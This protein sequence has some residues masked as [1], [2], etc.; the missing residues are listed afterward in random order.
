MCAFLIVDTAVLRAE[1]Q[2]QGVSA[3][4]STPLGDSRVEPFRG[5]MSTKPTFTTAAK[6]I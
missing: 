4:W 6:G 1:P 2:F 5:L 3:R